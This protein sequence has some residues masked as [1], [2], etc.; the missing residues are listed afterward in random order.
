MGL[1][2]I[3]QA[4]GLILLGIAA[5]VFATMLFRSPEMGP[6]L[7]MAIMYL[8]L[9]PIAMRYHGV[10]GLVAL[11]VV[12]LVVPVLVRN[13]LLNHERP[14]I[15]RPLLFMFVFLACIIVSAAASKDVTIALPWVAR[16]VGEGLVLYFLFL[17]LV[18]SKDSIRRYAWAL[19]LSGSLLASLTVYQE[20]TGSYTMDFGG[21]ASRKIGREHVLEDL[22][23]QRTV[24]RDIHRGQAADLDANRY[25]QILIVLFPMAWCLFKTSRRAT[26]KVVAAGCSL[27]IVAGVLLTYSRGAFVGLIGMLVLMGI[28]GIISRKNLLLAGVAV[29]LSILVLS[30][31]YVG[32]MGT[33]RG[34]EGLV[35]QGSE[36]QSAPDDVERTRATIM[37]AAWRVFLEHPVVGVGPGEF[38]ALYVMDY[39]AELFSMDTIDRQY[40][41]HS[42]YLQLAAETGV[43]GL[44][45]FAAI[46]IASLSG[47]LAIR[48]KA[49]LADPVVVEWSGALTVAIATY[50]VTGLFLHLA[51]QRYLW[52]LFG[53]GGAVVQIGESALIQNMGLRLEE[54]ARRSGTDPVT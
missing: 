1:A 51:Y 16:Y 45:A 49:R 43:V 25:A 11:P 31:G 41:A 42:L 3:A 36:N 53:L 5:L 17:N 10:P 2:V 14:I 15:D 30:P 35:D 7:A 21:L 22:Q 52:L 38:A 26:T 44:G 20:C 28:L 54:S 37:L 19:V 40:F 13:W 33:L 9:I 50:L 6:P 34:L 18:R 29:L 39:G 46:V 27:L 4:P 47:L 48:R 12:G 8:N 24:V 32:R 23:G